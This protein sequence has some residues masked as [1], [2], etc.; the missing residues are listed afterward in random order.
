ME[1][2][3]PYTGIA[4]L[5]PGYSVEDI[6]SDLNEEKATELLNAIAFAWH[7]S[8]IV[9]ADSI[10]HFRYAD[11]SDLMDARQILFIPGCSEE[12]MGHDWREQLNA[13]NAMLMHG[14]VERGDWDNAVAEAFES[15]SS[16]VAPELVH[17]FLAL[18]L[19]WFLVASL[20]RR[21]H[22]FIDP[23]ES[24]LAASI[25]DAAAAALENDAVRARQSLAAAFECLLETREQLFPMESS[26][27]DICL[28]GAAGDE[29][30]LAE[31]ITSC[32]G[33][34]LLVSPSELAQL[35]QRHAPLHALVKSA[36]AEG[37]CCVI[38]GGWHELRTSL[39]ALS[40]AYTDLWRG[41]ESTH[42]AAAVWG[43]KKF[44]LYHS[45]PS[46][47][48]L[49][50]VR[51]AAH[52][53][54]DD[55][56]YPER[57]YGQFNWQAPGNASVR[58]TSR[59]PVA[60]DTAVSFLRLPERLAET[61][62]QDAASTIM[63]ARLPELSSPWLGDLRRIHELC[64]LL[65]RFVTL[66]EFAENLESSMESVRF[67]PGDY[68]APYLI[69]A[70]VLKTEWPVTG[71]ADLH[72]AQQQLERLAF[73][74][75][76][77]TI[78]DPSTPDEST[79]EAL[80]LQL[81]DLQGDRLDPETGTPPDQQKDHVL[82][83]Q[84]AIEQ[85]TMSQ[86]NMLAGKL[87]RGPV[88]GLLVINPLPFAREATLEWPGELGQPKPSDSIIATSR[89]DGE[90]F[91]H[92]SVPPGG[93]L[94]LQGGTPGESDFPADASTG[95]PLA[96]QGVLRNQFFEVLMSEASGGIAD[97]RF[98]SQR[99]NRVSQQVA[100]RYDFPKPFPVTADAEVR[101]TNY[102]ETSCQKMRVIESG[103][104]R[105]SIEAECQIHD[106][107][108]GQL[109]LKFRQ[110]TTI[111]RNVPQIDITIVPEPDPDYSLI[112]N[113]W[114]KYFAC[115]FAWDNEAAAMTRSLL[116]QACGFSGERFESPDYIEV[117]DAD[118]RLLIV[119]H[120]R[121]YHRRSGPR[122]LDS[123]LLVDGQ[124]IPEGGFQFTLAFD[125][126]F[127]RRTV[128]DILQ[129]VITVP[130]EES[131]DTAAWLAGLSA[132]NVQIE[133]IRPK[134]RTLSIVL[135]ET[136]GRAANCQLRLAR[137]PIRASSQKATGRIV[138]EL[139]IN[140][141]GIRMNFSPFEIKEVHLTF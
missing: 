140:D 13:S 113:P 21:M 10:P 84:S 40:T 20:S 3:R 25:H 39:G 109:L 85:Q 75:A 131:G 70:A 112:G 92:C 19:S 6:P 77:V 97:V 29:S 108:D 81:Q 122:M 47:L 118:H 105:G 12:W 110:R 50:D 73:L 134:E 53:A 63:L 136:E 69:Q 61:M 28:P 64:P 78:L 91:V 72:I 83:L 54:L 48:D 58:A 31:L 126:P 24:R 26:L 102:A 46:L 51:F 89:Q 36:V 45:L 120:G 7:P 82:A 65:G 88:N 17:D 123:L 15:E 23:D 57:E 119:P 128:M 103:P 2:S 34:N 121:P 80:D 41:F 93:I 115:R 9:Q 27:I 30:V 55:G 86:A 117:A 107:Q 49:F 129:P 18:G 8:V 76:L 22:Y 44:G 71:P 101:K 96:E 130:V 104:W 67:Q 68:L 114:M 132:K 141:S 43:Q 52:V 138:E 1:A 94:Q 16:P 59:L 87:P 60:I 100:F 124:A 99:A 56:Q 74:Q 37:T 4:I 11:V 90:I 111:Q 14:P 66:S 79:L 42:P 98:H 116:G 38:S 62:Q 137:S 133:R 95:R 33:I 32:P 5:I 139:E 125:Q 106:V 135:Q 35:E 127:P